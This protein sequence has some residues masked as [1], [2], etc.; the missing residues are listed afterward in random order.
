M[1]SGVLLVVC[2]VLVAGRG[3]PEAGWLLCVVPW[4]ERVAG[5]SVG[6]DTCVM[7]TDGWP[8]EKKLSTTSELA[9]G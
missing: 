3:S 6:L 9:V 4:G 2:T 8:C 1:A 5:A 7:V